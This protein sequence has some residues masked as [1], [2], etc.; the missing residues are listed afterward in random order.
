MCSIFSCIL[1]S[2]VPCLSVYLGYLWD[3]LKK[4]RNYHSYRIRAREKLQSLSHFDMTYRSGSGRLGDLSF[5]SLA[6]CKGSTCMACALAA[7]VIPFFCVSLLV[8]LPFFVWPYFV[9]LQEMLGLLPF[10]IY[11][12]LHLYRRFL[13]CCSCNTLH[14]WNLLF[15]KRPALWTAISSP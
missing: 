9:P 7:D 11:Y 13:I 10:A 6:C 2:V 12:Y 3:K 5:H 14:F 15:R 4:K 8:F 1:N